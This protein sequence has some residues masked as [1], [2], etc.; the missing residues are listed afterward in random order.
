LA[1]RV[2]VSA[3]G[4]DRDLTEVLRVLHG[5]SYSCFVHAD[6]CPDNVRVTDGVCRIFDFE[7]SAAGCATL[8]FGYLLAPFP[9]CW[10]FA[11]LPAELSAKAQAAYWKAFGTSDVVRDDAWEV[12]TAAALSCYLVSRIG[13]FEDF[14]AGEQPWG[15]TTGG[16]RIV[17]WTEAAVC[18]AETAGVFPTLRS[19][20]TLIHERALS[21]V[22]INTVPQYPAVAAPGDEVVQVPAWWSEGL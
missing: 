10:C 16:P 7:L 4:T 2:G 19:L 5:D 8:D 9:S 15:T 13:G 18:C 11:P 12:A 6:A 22:N 17:T 14:L 21:T 20:F 3:E 1:D